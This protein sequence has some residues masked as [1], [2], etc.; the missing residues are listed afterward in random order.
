M[1]EKQT[2]ADLKQN[3]LDLLTKLDKRNI[4]LPNTKTRLQTKSEQDY[5][6]DYEDIEY[7]YSILK[8]LEFIPINDIHDLNRQAKAME[9]EMEQDD[10]SESTVSNIM[11]KLHLLFHLIL[12]NDDEDEVITRT[13]KGIPIVQTL[14]HRQQDLLNELFNIPLNDIKS[15]LMEKNIEFEKFYCSD[16]FDLLLTRAEQCS[17]TNDPFIEGLYLYIENKLRPLYEL[18]TVQLVTQMKEK[19][20][21]IDDGVITRKKIIEYLENNPISRG[22]TDFLRKTKMKKL[23][24]TD[25]LG[26][27]NK[28]FDTYCDKI[29]NPLKRKIYYTRASAA[30]IQEKGHVT[31]N[32]DLLWSSADDAN[33]QSKEPKIMMFS[34]VTTAINTLPFK[35]RSTIQSSVSEDVQFRAL[36]EHPSTVNNN[37]SRKAAKRKR[38]DKTNTKKRKQLFANK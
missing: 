25:D 1:V 37:K 12:S 38:R 15:H 6:I 16:T 28:L 26:P 23:L 10:D 22:L 21:D 5:N 7:R 31:E 8:D 13:V 34:K 27:Y 11:I 18:S 9:E 3:I 36:Y 29:D 4:R 35:N 33:T 24:L 20:F 30:T 17:L 2:A 14:E 19:Y 32:K